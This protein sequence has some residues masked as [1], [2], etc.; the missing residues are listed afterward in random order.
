MEAKYKCDVCGTI[1][2]VEK[3]EGRTNKQFVNEDMPHNLPCEN[4]QCAGTCY[5][6]NNT[7]KLVISNLDI[8]R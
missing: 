2:T 5:P 1:R 6:T 8:A 7:L 3:G 4:S